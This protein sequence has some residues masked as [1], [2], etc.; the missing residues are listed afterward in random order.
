MR[1]A[2]TPK[3]QLSGPTVH[4]YT[5]MHALDLRLGNRA[6]PGG[7]VCHDLYRRVSGIKKAWS[8][9]TLMGK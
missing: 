1:H 4:P 2:R 7:F 5:V 6:D 9:Y 3:V 8:L